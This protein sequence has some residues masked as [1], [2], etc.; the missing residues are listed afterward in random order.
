MT[1]GET[2]SATVRIT[3]TESSPLIYDLGYPLLL[4][5]TSNSET[6][7][8]EYTLVRWIT[9]VADPTDTDMDGM[10]DVYE[11]TYGLNPNS[12]ADA[13]GNLDGDGFTNLEEYEQRTNPISRDTDNDGVEDHLDFCP[14][15]EGGSVEGYQ[16]VCE[17]DVRSNPILRIIMLLESRSQD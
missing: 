17:A 12:A 4:E 8:N 10:T 6:I 15:D 5:V 14:L 2:Y 3:R 16:G 1:P 7:E 11:Q 9:F 13:S